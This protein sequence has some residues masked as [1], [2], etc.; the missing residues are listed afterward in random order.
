MGSM[1]SSSSSCCT[2]DQNRQMRQEDQQSD[3]LYHRRRHHEDTATSTST[4]NLQQFDQHLEQMSV[5]QMARMLATEKRELA[6]RVLTRAIRLSKRKTEMEIN[7][8]LYEKKI[9]EELVALK[10]LLAKLK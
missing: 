6:L 9:V 7:K 5:R 2:Q 3:Q 10:V 1:S 8:I 4:R